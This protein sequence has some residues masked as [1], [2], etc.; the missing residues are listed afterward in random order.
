MFTIKQSESNLWTVGSYDGGEWEPES[1]HRT[2]EAA[3]DH[4][5]YLNGAGLTEGRL[6]AIIREELRRALSADVAAGGGA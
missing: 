5:A 2:A 3:A 4:C 6:R 1:D